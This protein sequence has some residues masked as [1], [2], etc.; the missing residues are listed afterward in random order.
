MDR[1]LEFRDAAQYLDVYEVITV[2][3]L[4]VDNATHPRIVAMTDDQ[5]A[6]GHDQRGVRRSGKQHPRQAAVIDLLRIDGQDRRVIGGC[7]I[8]S[9]SLGP[10]AHIF[11]TRRLAHLARG[12]TGDTGVH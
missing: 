6:A 3:G 11:A 8:F 2:D 5:H 1:V 4:E 9:P 10:I 7:R 12:H